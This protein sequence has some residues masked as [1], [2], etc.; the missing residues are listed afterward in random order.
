MKTNNNLSII[1][2]NN[3]MIVYSCNRFLENLPGCVILIHFKIL[4]LDKLNI[5]SQI[6]HSFNTTSKNY[7]YLRL[8]PIILMLNVSFKLQ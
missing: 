3:T 5:T 7:T 4:C 6:V 2:I 1:D 8:A